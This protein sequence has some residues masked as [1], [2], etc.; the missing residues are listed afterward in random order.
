M[1]WSSFFS[2]NLIQ[3]NFPILGVGFS[4]FSMCFSFEPF[5]W[6]VAGFSVTKEGHVL[7]STCLTSSYRGFVAR[8]PLWAFSQNCSIFSQDECWTLCSAGCSLESSIPDGG[9][10]LR[11]VRWT[12]HT[13][14]AWD[15][16]KLLSGFLAYCAKW[17]L[18]SRQALEQGDVPSLWK[19]KLLDTQ[20]QTQGHTVSCG[21]GI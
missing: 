6:W 2:C 20:S 16:V 12:L 14:G 19:K 10:V 8:P 9:F 17:V 13:H 7:R 4:D 1:F 11:A 15:T 3:Q 21:V 5:W 18:V